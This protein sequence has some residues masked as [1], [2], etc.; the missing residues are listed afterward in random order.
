MKGPWR[1]ERGRMR[2]LS[3]DL[4]LSAVRLKSLGS[5]KWTPFPLQER[6]ARLECSHRYRVVSAS[7][8]RS[9]KV[10]PNRSLSHYSAGL[11]MIHLSTLPLHSYS[12]EGSL[13]PALHCF[14]FEIGERP[15]CR[16]SQPRM[17]PSPNSPKDSCLRTEQH[18][19]KLKSVP[20]LP[21]QQDH[22]NTSGRSL[23]VSGPATPPRMA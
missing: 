7:Q 18:R 2:K 3:S 1:T 10:H 22:R 11:G 15:L 14:R 12:L 21:S 19:L 20:Q 13:S 4:R 17:P 23:A 8:Y 6:L 16:L 9:G 5:W